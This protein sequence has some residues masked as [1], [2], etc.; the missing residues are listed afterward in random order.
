M[1]LI[2]MMPVFWTAT[3]LVLGSAG[4][5]VGFAFVN[6]MGNVTGYFGPLMVG[7]IT[8]ATGSFS[9]ALYILGIAAFIMGLLIF[10]LRP[11]LI[12][13]ELPDNHEVVAP[14]AQ[15]V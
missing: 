2:G 13:A 12:A 4:A 3:S 8:D 10:M 7:W 11:F 1:G 15:K 6:S 5:A 14:M 9:I